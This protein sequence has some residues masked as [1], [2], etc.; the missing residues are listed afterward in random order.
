[1]ASR[2]F[3]A[4][5]EARSR[6]DMNEVL[7]SVTSGHF[8]PLLRY[9]KSTPGLFL[10]NSI[11]PSENG[12]GGDQR[13][14][15]ANGFFNVSSLA[16]P[17]LLSVFALENFYLSPQTS[18]DVD[19]LS[20]AFPTLYNYQMWLHDHRMGKI[21][22]PFESG[23]ELSHPMWTDALKDVI[24]EMKAKSWTVTVPDDVK[25]SIHYPTDQP[26]VYL[27]CLYLLQGDPTV[28][29]EMFDPMFTAFITASDIAIYQI[30]VILDDKNE[31]VSSQAFSTV[32]KWAKATDAKTEALWNSATS[33]YSPIV[34][35]NN[36][37]LQFSTPPGSIA[38]FSP[39]FGFYSSIR[40]KSLSTP[41][42]YMPEYRLDSMTA[43][44]LSS[45]EPV[46]FN[47]GGSS[48][49][50]TTPCDMLPSPA[51]MVVD[52]FMNYVAG[53][54][55]QQQNEVGVAHFLRNSTLEMICANYGDV[56]KFS[57][58]YTYSTGDGVADSQCPN[59]DAAMPAAVVLGELTTELPFSFSSAP[60]LNNNWVL[61]II[62]SELFIVFGVSVGCLVLSVNLF[63][64]LRHQRKIEEDN[65]IAGHDYDD[66]DEF[67]GLLA[68]ERRGILG[69]IEEGQAPIEEKKPGMWSIL[70]S[71]GEVLSPW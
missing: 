20:K 24:A 38:D 66:Q 61:V 65:I 22:H 28:E 36:A 39:L 13:Y 1:M 56:C 57:H 32:T 46:S 53:R 30:G 26:D 42:Y 41:D 5:D 68:F 19:Q 7:L 44:V 67:E 6:G 51:S 55:F 59:N 71:V 69:E 62:V 60:P 63:R 29:F 4:F 3:A 11:Y 23:V 43:S 31:K 52:P 17:P 33:R 15:S 58:F 18:A 35:V 8:I 47:C 12:W 34:V 25:A 54:G 9:T 2:G 40:E 64:K 70:M 10:P 37:T 27:A 45:A 48:P 49:Y 50:P 16:A 21:L 14:T